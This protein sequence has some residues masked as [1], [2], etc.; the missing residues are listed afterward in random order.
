M[1]KLL[2]KADKGHGHVAHVTPQSAGWTY[3]GFDLHRLR[4]GETAAGKTGEREVC[5]VFVTGKGQA[6]AGGKDLGLLGERMSPFEGK[7]WS[8]YVPQGSDWS[9]TADTE[10]EL[11][12]CSAPGLG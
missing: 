7:P 1:S 8:V 2:V 3:V 5:L 11:A 9:V 12:V 10:L 6:A 4:P